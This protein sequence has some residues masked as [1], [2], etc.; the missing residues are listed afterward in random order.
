MSNQSNLDRI[1]QATVD[2]IASLFAA[3]EFNN[4][5]CEVRFLDRD[6]HRVCLG[7]FPTDENGEYVGD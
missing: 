6:Y 1:T 3:P 2:S 5:G 4:D 7:L